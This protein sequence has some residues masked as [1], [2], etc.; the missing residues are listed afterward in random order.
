MAD[1]VA[2]GM[3]TAITIS[4]FPSRMSAFKAGSKALYGLVDMGRYFSLPLSSL[5]ISN[6]SQ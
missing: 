2:D 3:N 1:N 6:I 4:N 5:S